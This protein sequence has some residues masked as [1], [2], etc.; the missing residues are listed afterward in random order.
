[1]EQKEIIALFEKVLDQSLN[2]EK[3]A[4][5]INPIVAK[6]L[7]DIKKEQVL[8]AEELAAR[9]AAEVKSTFSQFLGDCV[10][11]SKGQVPAFIPAEKFIKGITNIDPVYMASL[12]PKEQKSLYDSS[13]AAGGYLV[14]TEESRTLLDLTTNWEVIPPMCTQVPMRTHQITF[15]TLS[16]GITAYWI[17]EAT[18]SS[19]SGQSEGVKQESDPTFGQMTITAHVLAV[20]VYV[21]NQLLDDSDPAV[22]TVLFN[23]FAK[24]LGRYLDIACLRGAGTA[25]DPVT[26]LSGLITTNLLSAGASFDFDDIINVI[27]SVLDNSDGGT[28]QVDVI[29]HTKAERKLMKVKDND[30][31]YIYKRPLDGRGLPS[32]YGEPW[33]RDNNISI[34]LGA[35]SNETR[36][37]S[38]DFANFAYVGS[39]SQIVI[40]ANPWGTGFT[41]NQTAFLAEF[42]KGFAVSDETRFANLS[43]VPTT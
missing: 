17:P 31:Q 42:R 22:D 20:L 8:T 37:F 38:G 33:H 6:A 4:P 1:M 36:I 19:P 26:G 11:M 39:R 5:F 32:I 13:N 21:S 40:K 28:T 23:L 24:T 29:G 43:G 14:P 2:E 18:S 15:P 10:R 9:Q 12:G 7:A 3:L 27:Y 30:G 25:T 34:T 16:A 41:Q 35:G